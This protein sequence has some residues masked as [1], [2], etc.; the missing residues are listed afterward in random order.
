MKEG[1]ILDILAKIL[2]EKLKSTNSKT[3]LFL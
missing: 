1:R 2:V 3:L